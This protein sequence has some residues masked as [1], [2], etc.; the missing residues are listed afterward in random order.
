MD[1]GR[2]AG[3]RITLA[4]EGDSRAAKNFDL[5]LGD[6][7]R[8]RLGRAKEND[9]II[10]QKG[11]SSF[12]CEFRFLQNDGAATAELHIRDISTNG[13]GLKAPGHSAKRLQ[14]GVDTVVADGSIVILPFKVKAEETDN[15]EEL[16]AYIKVSVNALEPPGAPISTS[17]PASEFRETDLLN[18]PPSIPVPNLPPSIPAA[19]G[20]TPR[21]LPQPLP[22]R[23]SA[24]P[25]APRTIPEDHPVRE[26][27]LS[28]RFQPTERLHEHRGRE[29]SPARK[30]DNFAASA[31]GRADSMERGRDQR[32]REHSQSRRHE[33]N[34]PAA[35][36]RSERA[37][38]GPDRREPEQNHSSRADNTERGRG[39]RERE[40]SRSKRGD[41]ER[42]ERE[43][44]R[45]RRGDR[46]RREHEPSRS[47]RGD[48]ERRD[49]ERSRSRRGDREQD[50]GGNKDTGRDRMRDSNRDRDRER[51]RRSQDPRRNADSEHADRRTMQNGMVQKPALDEAQSLSTPPPPPPPPLREHATASKAASPVGGKAKGA[52]LAGMQQG[53][54][55]PMHAM[56]GINNMMGMNNTMGMANMAMTGMPG[57]QGMPGQF[58]GYGHP[59]QQPPGHP[60]APIGAPISAPIG[61][62]IG[63]PAACQMPGAAKA[64]NGAPQMSWTSNPPP[65]NFSTNTLANSPGA[66]PKSK[67]PPP[68]L[69]P[70]P[71]AATSTDKNVDNSAGA[72]NASPPVCR[73]PN[74]SGNSDSETK[75]SKIQKFCDRFRLDERSKSQ[76]TDFLDKRDSAYE[77]DLSQLYVALEGAG[78]ASPSFVLAAK[79]REMR[80]GESHVG[81]GVGVA[82]SQ[83]QPEKHNAG[84]QEWQEKEAQEF[85][86]QH[87]IDDERLKKRF[88]EALAKRD[89]TFSQDMSHLSRLMGRANNP[90]GLLASQ[91]K[92]MENGTFEVRGGQGKGGGKAENG[93]KGGGG[94]GG[95]GDGSWGRNWR[96]DA[97]DG[98]DSKS[99][100]GSSNGTWGSSSWGTSSWGDKADDS[101][102]GRTNSSWDSAK[103]AHASSS[104]RGTSNS[105][106]SKSAWGRGSWDDDRGAQDRQ[107]NSK[108]ERSRSRRRRDDE[109]DDNE[110]RRRAPRSSNFS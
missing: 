104:W 51:E 46:E 21:P 73:A 109:S 23:V 91:V 25:D 70:P 77:N 11:T 32:D 50:R 17:A 86:T 78:Q 79:L 103:Q 61:A 34:A 58:V 7:H 49:R 6:Q 66:T 16:R 101:G 87:K 33:D 2:A 43:R 83:D 31:S 48:R 53:M 12:H 3:A 24:T 36:S 10:E 19:S 88:F 64:A 69:P 59:S 84:M 13:V 8:I 14:K 30:G 42:R 72:M 90:F 26:G 75:A 81:P 63:R 54:Q 106:S 74:S 4:F 71:P 18:Y 28:S 89:A 100:G 45:S 44:S 15:L 108:A 96:A 80:F 52:S 27:S 92:Q 60:G 67:A 39:R 62:P 97:S 47:R 5:S 98:W 40:R 20:R 85:L 95:G 55:Q 57:V 29:W 41:R 38:Q 1:A 107:G 76:L 37:E 82:S 110:Q 56:M 68:A 94:S 35:S 99:W 105:G 22:A 93:C 102:A 65:G 9:V